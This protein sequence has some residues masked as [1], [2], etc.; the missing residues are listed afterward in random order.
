MEN[1]NTR[2]NAPLTLCLRKQ[3]VQDCQSAKSEVEHIWQWKDCGCVYLWLFF[4]KDWFFLLVRRF[5]PLQELPNGQELTVLHYNQI[6]RDNGRRAEGLEEEL[7]AIQAQLTVCAKRNT[8]EAIYKVQ[9]PWIFLTLQELASHK[10]CILSRGN[11]F[12]FVSIQASFSWLEILLLA[13]SL[14]VKIF[15][16]LDFSLTDRHSPKNFLTR[17]GLGGHCVLECCICWLIIEALVL[18]DSQSLLALLEA[19]CLCQFRTSLHYLRHW[20]HMCHTWGLSCLHWNI[21]FMLLVGLVALFQ[22]LNCICVTWESTCFSWDIVFVL[23][24]SFTCF[25][26][27]QNETYCH[28]ETCFFRKLDANWKLWQCGLS[29]ALFENFGKVLEVKSFEILTDPYLRHCFPGMGRSLYE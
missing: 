16:C 12:V 4:F 21:L 6:M 19:F 13:S 10:D 24:V 26:R 11:C 15:G 28:V 20:L 17:S 18:L 7:A 27:G 1:K 5:Q 3:I 14:F 22:T 9:W 25:T 23:L 29:Q 8:W 2:T